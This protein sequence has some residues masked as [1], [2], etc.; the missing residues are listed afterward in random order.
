MRRP[1][2]AL[3]ALALLVPA[4]PAAAAGSVSGLYACS[5]RGSSDTTGAML[6]G[7]LGAFAGSR[8]SKHY[9]TLGAVVGAGLGSAIGNSIGCQMDERGQSEAR[10]AFQRALDTGRP[11]SWTDTRSGATGYIEVVRPAATAHAPSWRF[12]KGVTSARRSGGS[13]G[14][15][16]VAGHKVAVRAAPGPTAPVVHRIDAGADVEVAGAVAKGVWLAVV[17]GGLVQGYVPASTLRPA[18]RGY[19]GAS[20]GGCRLV[21]QTVTEPGRGQTYESYTACRDG[22]GAWSLNAV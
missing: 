13:T 19:A 10:E 18:P 4:A 15:V 11:Q 21:S 1:L 16:Y 22:T 7:L 6:G 3:A 8:V 2:L 17:D 20:N 5:A 12:A 9:R 14:G